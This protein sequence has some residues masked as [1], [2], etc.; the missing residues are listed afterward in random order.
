MHAGDIRSFDYPVGEF[1]CVIHAANDPNPTLAQQAPLTVL[2]TIVQGTRHTLDF[3][4]Q[5]GAQSFLLTSSGAVYGPQPPELS[6]VPESYFGAPDPTLPASLYGEGKRQAEL[7]CA[8]YSKQYGLATKIARCFAFVGPYLP[9]D[10]NFA[11]GNFVRDALDGGPLRIQGDGTPYRS[12]LY[13]ADLAAWLWTIL[14]RGEPTRAYNVGSEE[15]IS[16]GELAAMV[17]AQSA[18]TPAIEI[19]QTPVPGAAPVRYIPSTKRAREELGV[20]TATGLFEA[21][22]K[23]VN[24]QTNRRN[25]NA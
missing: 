20:R 9:L 3:A 19:A 5:C 18:T 21:L 6:H 17:V 22:Q 4:R 7:L 25:H 2:D 16:I 12:Y 1:A 13:A 10:A 24:W 8:L 14:D 11:I 15:A 23:T